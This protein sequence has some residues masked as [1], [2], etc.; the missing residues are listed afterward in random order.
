[1]TI[2]ESEYTVKVDRRSTQLMGP[3]KPTSAKPLNDND[4]QVTVREVSKREPAEEQGLSGEMPEP[5][6]SSVVA[7]V[8][9]SIVRTASLAELVRFCGAGMIVFAL[10]LFLMQGVDATND[11][12][13]FHLLLLQ[14]GLL[15]VSGF[16][17][18]YLLKEPRGA[19]VFFS[20]GLMSIPANMA[21]LGAMIYSVVNAGEL[22]THYP[23]YAN[24]QASNL[25]EIATALATGAVVLVPMALFAFSVFARQSRVWLTA[26]YLLSSAVLLVP[27]RGTFMI[28]VM[29]GLLVMGILLLIRR[30][31]VSR[32]VVLTA[33]E[34]FSQLLLF[35]P[36]VLMVVR[37][38]MLYSSEFSM[39][40][41][42]FS[43]AYLVLRF[44]SKQL[45]TASWFANSVHLFT[46]LAAVFLAGLLSSLVATSGLFMAPNLAFC[47][48]LGVLLLDLS[49]LVPSPAVRWWMHMGWALL[50]VPAF[51]GNYVFLAGAASIIVT[52]LICTLMIVSGILFKTRLVTILGILALIGNVL[53]QGSYMTHLLFTSNWMTLA[54]A[55]AVIVVAG[56]LI[57]R[58]GVSGRLK[59]QSWMRVYQ[60]ENLIQSAVKQTDEA[61]A[62]VTL[63]DSAEPEN[64]AA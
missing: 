8:I 25:T 3:P 59:I 60:A 35:L 19:R 5:S 63:D 34:R 23:E 26:G 58:Y 12:Q 20:L 11:L 28:T 46:A 7:S 57:E 64:L 21:V 41:S 45:K 2:N 44:S 55:G 39:L 61:A 9:K 31:R 29:A 14:T 53:M 36:P 17:V 52:L 54:A 42:L 4:H 51:F 40:V 33:E 49:R 15:G 24:W 16:A 47:L 1:M 38:A 56:S 32:E 6:K 30:Q 50:C 10:S 18:G 22:T 37:S 43:I 27:V 48:I 13:R 62:A